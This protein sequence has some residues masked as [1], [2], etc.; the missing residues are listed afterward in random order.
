[1]D[2]HQNCEDVIRSLKSAWTRGST[3]KCLDNAAL[4]LR[5][6]AQILAPSDFPSIETEILER[7]SLELPIPPST[8][9]KSFELTPQFLLETA[10]CCMKLAFYCAGLS[11]IE[12]NDELLKSLLP[13]AAVLER[14]RT[15]AYELLPECKELFDK[16]RACTPSDYLTQTEG[17][18][19]SLGLVIYAVHN[20][21]LP[22]LESWACFLLLFHL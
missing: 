12:R 10:G 2:E 19:Y 14:Q 4:A 3:W 16:T 22:V 5:D 9:N 20:S 18:L 8:G 21:I 6:A 7:K 15:L 13:P 1:M 17:F 11:A